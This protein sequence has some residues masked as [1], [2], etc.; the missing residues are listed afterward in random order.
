MNK[1]MIDAMIPRAYEQ[2]AVCK[3]ANNGTVQGTFRGQIAA[4]GA[5]VAMGSLL[6][7]VAFFSTKGGSTVERPRLMQAIFGLLQVPNEALNE[8]VRKAEASQQ[9]Y[10][11][12]AG[13]PDDAALRERV[14]CAAVA[15]KLAMNLYTRVDSTSKP[16]GG[17]SA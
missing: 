17:V 4:F 12:V 15:L 8:T 1:A 2:L 16:D 14:L 13:N 3:I 11:Y 9:L 6:S 7:A 5:S 10:Q